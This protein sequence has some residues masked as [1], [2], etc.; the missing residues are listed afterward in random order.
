MTELSYRKLV[1]KSVVSECESAKSFYLVPADLGPLY[2]HLP[3]QHLPLRLNIP[4]HPHPVFRCYTISNYGDECYRLTIKREG[5]AA[6]RPAVDAGSSSGYFHDVVHIND[7]LEARPPS[8]HFWLDLQQDKP[9]VML[10]GGVGVT[11]IMSMLEALDQA[12][13]KRDVY[14]L[15]GVRNAADH[16][17]RDRLSMI[18]ARWPNLQMHVFYEQ[19]HTQ[20]ISGQHYHHLGK[21]DISVLPKQFPSLDL[22]YYMCGPP[23]MMNSLSTVLRAAGVAPER[24][25]TE[26]FGPSSLSLQIPTMSEQDIQTGSSNINVTFAKSGISAPWTGELHSLLQLA[27]INGV[28]INSGCQYGDC[29]TCMVRLLE[30][31]VMYPHATG[32]RPDPTCCLPCSCCPVTSVVLDA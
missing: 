2:P 13:F 24:I 8:G 7:V 3:G 29:G 27:Q 22:D 10:A 32:A 5:P 21:I 12:G 6:N 18:A 25:A 28:E 23:A 31:Q 30:G 17:F 26:S 20:G 16:V 9:I 11:P 19:P 15:F 1:V 4:G 14:F